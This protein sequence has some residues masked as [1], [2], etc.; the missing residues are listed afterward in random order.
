[1]SEKKDRPLNPEFNP[2]AASLQSGTKPQTLRQPVTGQTAGDKKVQKVIAG[3]VVQKK[4]TFW[5]K[6]SETFTPEDM[7]SVVAY[8]IWD[9]LI[10]AA[11]DTLSDMVDGVKDM[12]LYGDSYRG[13]SIARRD[14]GKPYV[15]YS[16]Y[17]NREKERSTSSRP[18]ERSH[19]RRSF[20]DLVFETRGDAL[21]VL[22]TMVALIMEYKEV[23]V[24]D[25]YD[26]VDRPSNYTDN[27]WGWTDLSRADAVKIREGWIITFPKPENLE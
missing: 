2:V 7:D 18:A 25:L 5:K 17:Y 11:K 22:D 15:S 26:L 20:D 12:V 27:K 23:S 24:A 3:K 19:S 10:P 16:S 6:L 8:V 21:K 1:M 13:R 4:K 9:V 14:K